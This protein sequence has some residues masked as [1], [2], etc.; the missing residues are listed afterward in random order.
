MFIIV[1][2]FLVQP[3][4][5]EAFMATCL[6]DAKDSVKN[7]PGCH[8]FEVFTEKDEPNRIVLIEVYTDE[9]AF[10]A[11]LKT[12]HFAKF[13]AATRGKSAEGPSIM[14]LFSTHPSDA[15]FKK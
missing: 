12:P 3:Q 9:A 8:R 14:R 2:N 10:D 1:A 6:E 4:H 11:H 15:V 13:A 5:R 7:E